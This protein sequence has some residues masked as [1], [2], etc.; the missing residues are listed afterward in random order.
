MDNYCSVTGELRYWAKKLTNWWYDPVKDEY[1]YTTST[2]PPSIDAIRLDE[3][4]LAIADRIDAEHE[5]GMEERADQYSELRAEMNNCYIEMPKDADGEVIHVGDEL[6]DGWHEQNQGE[7]EWLMLNNHGWWLMLK[8]N[9]ERFYA[10]DFHE[11]HHRHEPTVEDVLREFAQRWDDPT[12]Y[13]KG[14]LVEQYASKL[15]LA[16]G[17]AE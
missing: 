15:R 3:H 13:A 1:T 16:G 5:H 8:N 10:H 14:E 6:L 11:W 12:H 7:V 2:M 17:D 9:C 4:I